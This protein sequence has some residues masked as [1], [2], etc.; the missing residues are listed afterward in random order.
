MKQGA[1]M[2]TP[3][4]PPREPDQPGAQ[5]LAGIQ[6]P[7][8]FTSRS[9]VPEQE[10]WRLE[11]IFPDDAAWEAAFERLPALLSE[12]ISWRGLLALSPDNL[13]AALRGSDE[14]EQECLELLAY[15]RM[16]RDEDNTQSIYQAMTDR[17]TAFYYQFAE[18]TAF[19]LPEMAQ[20]DAAQLQSWQ[21]NTAA[22]ADFRMLIDN[23]IRNRPHTLSEAEE[24]SDARP[25]RPAARAS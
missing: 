4:D 24:A 16:H 18:Q 11:D 23:S 10:R 17:I 2:E 1:S 15:A 5:H 12:L 8:P 6:S 13:A 21:A 25:L 20:I 22:L 9:D 19:I 14:L 3:A 7:G